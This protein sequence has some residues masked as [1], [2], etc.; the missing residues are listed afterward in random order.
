MLRYNTWK[1][2]HEE[3]GFMTGICDGPDKQGS[4]GW[5]EAQ[6]IDITSSSKPFTCLASC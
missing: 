6:V 1:R 5:I 4:P 3:A 2:I